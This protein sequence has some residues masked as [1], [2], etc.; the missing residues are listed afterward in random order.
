MTDK[1]TIAL[2][3]LNPTVGDI[4]GNAGLV[5][6]ARARAAEMGADL[7]V[8]SELVVPGYPPEDLVVRRSFQEVEFPKAVNVVQIRLTVF[9]EVFEILFVS[10]RDPE[11]VHCNKH[12]GSLL[13]K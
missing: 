12:N 4:D 1:L 6:A 3:Q 2:A 13:E 11:T 5:R 8:A 7:L 9:P 10:R